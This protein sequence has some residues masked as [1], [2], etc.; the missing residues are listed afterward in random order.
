[1]A[2]VQNAAQDSPRAAQDTLRTSVDPLG[3]P[4]EFKYGYCSNRKLNVVILHIFHFLFGYQISTAI[5]HLQIVPCQ[6]LHVSHSDSNNFTNCTHLTNSPKAP[7][8]TILNLPWTLPDP[9]WTLHDLP[10]SSRDTKCCSRNILRDRRIY[11]SSSTTSILPLLIVCELFLF[12]VL[13]YD[14]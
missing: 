1:M 2:G 3:R 12:K 5:V 7:S 13:D 6:L 8:V 11:S 10:R 4:C 9:H 14:E